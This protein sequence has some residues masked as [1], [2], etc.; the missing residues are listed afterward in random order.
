MGSPKKSYNGVTNESE[1]S[2]L[3]NDSFKDY[4]C[5]QSHMM[6]IITLESIVHQLIHSIFIKSPLGALHYT[7]NKMVNSQKRSLRS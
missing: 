2:P 5:V 7:K 1:T 4:I 3:L 6:K